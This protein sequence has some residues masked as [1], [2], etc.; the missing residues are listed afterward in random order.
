VLLL[1]APLPRLCGMSRVIAINHP[2][3]SVARAL[4]VSLPTRQCTVDNVVLLKQVLRRHPGVSPVHLRLVSG[5]RILT[6]ALD[7]V[8]RVTPSAALIGDLTALLGAA[9]LPTERGR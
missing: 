7:P 9:C 1:A 4:P 8:F 5:D 6:I 3:G 2:N